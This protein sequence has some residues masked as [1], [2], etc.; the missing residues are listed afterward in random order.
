[1]QRARRSSS[2][3]NS[4]KQHMHSKTE[5]KRSKQTKINSSISFI[6]TQTNSLS[7]NTTN[8]AIKHNK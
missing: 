2:A 7:F 6:T 3:R 4:H 1:M 8:S 5:A